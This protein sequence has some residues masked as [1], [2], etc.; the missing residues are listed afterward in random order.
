M[1]SL[2]SLGILTA[3]LS[4]GTPRQAPDGTAL[5]DAHCNK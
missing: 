4:V 1:P 2:F 3:A 5:F